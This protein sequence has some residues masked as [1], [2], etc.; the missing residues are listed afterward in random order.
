[1]QN[2]RVVAPIHNATTLHR[3]CG[4]TGARVT[5]E[6]QRQP[7]KAVL[8]ISQGE[9]AEY[10]ARQKQLAHLK[11]DQKALRASPINRLKGGAHIDPGR[12]NAVVHTYRQR[13][14][15]Q[16]NLE[17]IL[18][19]DEVERLKGLVAPLD[20]DQLSVTAK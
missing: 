2:D 17:V 16:G 4:S 9:L 11:R 6:Q 20:R 14:L 7:L 10:Y 15:T 3:S 19:T 12:L 8:R 1:M 13:P 5:A 18:G